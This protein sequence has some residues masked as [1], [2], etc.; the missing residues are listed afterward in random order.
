MSLDD[1]IGHNFG[2]KP[3]MADVNPDKPVHFQMD[4]HSLQ[5]KVN[6]VPWGDKKETT[7]IIA[8]MRNIKYEH[9]DD[10]DLI[11]DDGQHTIPFWACE[12]AQ[13]IIKEYSQRPKKQQKQWL[14]LAY[15]RSVYKD[16]NWE[17]AEKEFSEAAF[18]VL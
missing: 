18:A 1:I 16:T 2:G 7:E 10:G 6:E 4:M 11:V 9:T 3:W 12:L 5:L 15:V 14:D 8:E 17:G 13:T